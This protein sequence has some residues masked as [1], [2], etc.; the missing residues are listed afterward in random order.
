MRGA[1]ERRTVNDSDTDKEEECGGGEG[2]EGEEERGQT[3]SL[4]RPVNGPDMAGESR[5]VAPS[6]LIES[7]D[8][9]RPVRYGGRVTCRLLIAL[10]TGRGSGGEGWGGGAGGGGGL[11]TCGALV[12]PR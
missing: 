10:D 3:W 8:V 5:I 11:R 12:N 7:E 6:G 9:P 1:D 4:E 2:G